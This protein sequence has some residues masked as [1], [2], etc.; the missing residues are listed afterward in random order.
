MTRH[1]ICRRDELREGALTPLRAGRMPV[2]AT[3]VG[4]APTVVVARCPH[5]GADLARGAVVD[6]VSVDAE[7]CIMVDPDRAVL[8]CPW[9]G[10]EFDILT[11]EPVVP[12]PPHLRLRLRHLDASVD[13]D[14]I[15]VDI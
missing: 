2:V 1:V 10:F 15:V 8:R 14:D 9:H 11:G 12:A 3:L 4:G 7:G 5:Q 6:H 13:G